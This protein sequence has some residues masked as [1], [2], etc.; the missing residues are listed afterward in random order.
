MERKQLVDALSIVRP[1]LASSDLVQM[2]THLCFS[3]REVLAYNDYIGM[4]APL[5]AGFTGTIPG[6]T[7]LALLGASKA[8]QVDFA[9]AGD[10][11]LEVRAARAK[12][13]FPLTA[14]DAFKF[15][16][17]KLAGDP[18]PVSSEGF[19]AGLKSCLR[20]V[21]D[22]TSVPDQLGVTL[23]PKK[24]GIYMYSINGA[25]MSRVGI[26]LSGEQT[27]RR[28]VILSSMFCEQLIRLG[29]GDEGAQLVVAPDHALFRTSGRAR[30]F[31]KLINAP[32]PLDFEGLFKDILPEDLKSAS[33]KIPP[34]FR[35]AVDRAVIVSDQTGERA[36]SKLSIKAGK[37]V[38]RTNS[39]KVDLVDE[40][41][42]EGHPDV[43]VSADAKWLKVG[44]SEADRVLVTE[45]AVIFGR[46]SNLYLVATTSA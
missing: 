6:N 9:P 32:K 36:Y 43:E 14:L 42:L 3:E 12:A 38:L 40:F 1:A 18:L 24:N 22:D 35:E 44:V 21:S 39:G 45:R 17:P 7:F 26:K 13:K 15:S 28:R 10:G 20:S 46:A 29:A 2:L 4:S 16:M 11:L 8:T 5:R 37:A 31:G 19:I 33:V 23:I 27:F 41:K 25:S 30:L 34:E